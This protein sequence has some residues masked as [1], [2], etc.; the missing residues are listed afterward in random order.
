LY[1]GYSSAA[2]AARPLK[3]ADVHSTVSA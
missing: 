2:V 1:S 3:S